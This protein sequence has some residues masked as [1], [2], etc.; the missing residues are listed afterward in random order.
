[1]GDVSHRSEVISSQQPAALPTQPTIT[2]S[3]DIMEVDDKQEP[4]GNIWLH[5]SAGPGSSEIL[6][7]EDRQPETQA[8]AQQQ[9]KMVE[10][11]EDILQLEWEV[12]F[13]A[14]KAQL[15]DKARSELGG[16]QVR[17]KFHVERIIIL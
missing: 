1:M 16:Q 2:V 15:A 5:Y 3:E 12:G 13:A 14:V 8:M 9:W 10:I 17:K 11:D 7:L 6:Q 4:L